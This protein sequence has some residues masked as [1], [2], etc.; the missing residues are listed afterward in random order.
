MKHRQTIVAIL[1]LVGVLALV[2][3]CALFNSP[4]SASFVAST[5]A[6]PAPLAVSF[7]ATGSSDSGGIITSYN[8]SFGDGQNG[9]G[10]T[11]LHVYQNAGTYTA[12]LTVID[13]GGALDS[14]SQVITVSAPTNLQPTASFT[15]IPSSGPAPLGVNFNAMASS[16]PDGT[17]A[18]FEWNF[19]DGDH[20]TGATANHT[21]TN[22]GAYTAVL[23]V[24]D[25]KGATASTTRSI[26]VTV[27]GNALPT[28]SFT[29]DPTLGFAP[30]TVDFDASASS[31]P[32][33]SIT[34]YHWDFGDT[35]TGSG[36]T[37]SHTYSNAGSYLV[38]LTVIDDQ[39]AFSSSAETIKVYIWIP[40]PIPFP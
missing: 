40:F 22:P 38:V 35:T 8:W 3:G 29:A 39:G 11:V 24:T 33:G 6:G 12:I 14:A 7:D 1:L 5:T 32:D 36:I 4:P 34:S 13:D 37:T 25:D 16:D 26:T 23:T 17:I 21:Y 27:P 19:G 28:A 20:A 18:T 30:V 15:A 2:A 31:D 10:A 9:S